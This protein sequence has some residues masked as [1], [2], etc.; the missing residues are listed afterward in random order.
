MRPLFLFLLI[1][2]NLLWAGSY[3]IFKML[4]EHLASGS[5]ATLR[6]GLAALGLLAVWPLLPGRGPRGRDQIRVV[7]IGLFVFCL[8]PRLQIE[9][10]HRGQAGDTSLLIALDPLITSIAAALFLREQIAPRRWW[11]CTLG[12]VGVMLISQVWLK[13]AQP[14]HGLLANL[15]FISSFFCEATYSVLGKPALERVGT[16]KLLGAGLLAGTSMNVAI[17]L[18]TRAPTFTAVQVLPLKAWLLLIYLAVVCT[19]VGYS[20]WFVVI[21]K[22]EV[23]IAGM[24]IFAQ[25]VAGLALSVIWLGESLHW[26]Q[27]WGSLAITVGLVI[28]LRPERSGRS[29]RKEMRAAL[30]SVPLPETNDSGG[31]GL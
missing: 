16:L 4:G 28:A 10:V 8:A 14:L 21:R 26:G 29:R 23:N 27:L 3:P 22:T 18:M 6:F 9:G 31:A 19:L 1:G 2:M 13:N 12:I 11:G 17:D 5:I 20:L 15:L 24:T 25:P 7:L 30:V